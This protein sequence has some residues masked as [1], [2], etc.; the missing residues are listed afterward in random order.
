MGSP[1]SKRIRMYTT[2]WCGDCWRAKRFLKSNN[3][4]FE[5]VNIGGNRE[6]AQLVME[7]NYGKR[8]V[9]TF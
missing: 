2:R 9:P 1:D 3:I 6:A 7:H 5:E 8:R 4:E